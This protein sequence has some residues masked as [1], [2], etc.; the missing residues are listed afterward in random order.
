MHVCVCVCIMYVHGD[1]SQVLEER[2]K[3]EE[4][5]QGEGE[6]GGEGGGMEEEE[7]LSDKEK[8]EVTKLCQNDEPNSNQ[9]LTKF[10]F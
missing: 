8:K 4:E 7:P 9:N 3:E 2:V 1:C 5:G 6:E 10:F